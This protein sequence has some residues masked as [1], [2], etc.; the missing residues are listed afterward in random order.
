[1]FPPHVDLP[2]LSLG[3]PVGLVQVSPGRIAVPDRSE[4]L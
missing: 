2:G 4:E 3:E 1:M